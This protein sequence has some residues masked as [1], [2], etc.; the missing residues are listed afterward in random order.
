M[1][2]KSTKAKERKMK[3]K[4]ENEKVVAAQA[5]VDAANALEDPL[6]DLKAFR[7]FERNGISVSIDC[8]RVKDLDKD[9]TDWIFQLTKANM[10]SLYEESEWGWNDK[11]KREE[12]TE[13]A[14]WYLVCTNE[15]NEKV[16]CVHFRFDLDNDD[17]VLYCYEIQL[18][19]CVRRKGLGK[20]LMQILELIAHRTQLKKVM[21]TAF[22]NNVAA[23]EFFMTKLKYV[24]DETSPEDPVAEAMFDEEV[25]SYQIL[26]KAIPQKKAAVAKAP[27]RGGCCASQRCSKANFAV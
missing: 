16:A 18:E 15:D 7:K 21:L 27:K 26:S 19:K 8:K 12:M 14:A 13:D 2:R 17:E 22:K 20:F 1:G 5:I 9:T 6:A 10:Q 4:E 3:W 25:F 11:Q 24:V 23:T